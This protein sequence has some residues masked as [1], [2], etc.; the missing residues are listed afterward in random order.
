MCL[1]NFWKRHLLLFFACL[2]S[3]VLL[4]QSPQKDSVINNLDSVYVVAFRSKINSQNIPV[5]V[6]HLS[7]KVLTQEINATL[8]PAIN[9]IAGVKMEQRSPGSY[10]LAIRGS[11]LRSPFGIRNV[12]VYWN[13]ITFTDP[14]GNTYLN[15]LPTSL[16]NTIDIIK[17]P[18]GASYGLGTGGAVL[19]QSNFV[20]DSTTASS[21]LANIRGGSFGLFGQ[22][23]RLT[24][25]Y[26]KT[27]QTF[28]VSNESSNGW[29][30][31]SATDKKNITWFTST[32]SNRQ[33]LHTTLLYTDLMYQTPGGLTLGQMQ[34]NPKW[35][36]QATS[37][38]PGA[39]AQ[40]TAVFNKTLLGSVRHQYQFSKK[41]SWENFILAAQ[42]NFKNPFIT[43]YETRNE[44]NV[45]MGSH[46]TYDAHPA[47]GNVKI[48]MGG[49]WQLQHA[50]IHNY[51]NK[52][53]IID[54]LQF[55]D[56]IRTKQGFLFINTTLHLQKKWFIELGISSAFNRYNYLRTSTTILPRA[57]KVNAGLLAP[58]LGVSYALTPHANLYVQISKGFSPP[59]LAEI[60]PS[61]GL[62]YNA[63]A[64]EFGWNLEGGI[65][66]VAL[67]GK[68]SYELSWYHF[69]VQDA[70]VRQNTN[71]GIE[72]FV[73]AGS[74]KQGGAEMQMMYKLIINKLHQLN[75][76]IGY[77]YQPYRFIHYVQAGNSY[78]G[79]EVTGNAKYQSVVSIDYNYN[80][81]LTAFAT[82]QTLS[83]V[84]LTDANDVYAPA[85]S[86]V[87]LGVSYNHKAIRYFMGIDNVFNTSYSLGND[88][89][90]AGKRY[91]NP[92]APKSLLVGITA[93]LIK[94]SR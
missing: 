43:N 12:K 20:L 61:D 89:N 5:S 91:Y 79:K 30:E 76:K 35:A 84:P 46:I 27:Q 88:I 16:I 51:G 94:R 3:Y 90:A 87:Q 8:L 1:N 24:F 26:K 9:S 18:V 60:R 63:L 44:K 28:F 72:Y 62:F 50:L 6:A 81:K 33:S 93:Q 77:A 69:D 92:A 66:G 19:L 4:A 58:Q 55:A 38:L 31:Q 48:V 39:V 21:T 59:T 78:D 40:Q 80:K 70:I 47:F 86:L 10:R 37:A 13:Q 52:K 75:C 23:V 49:E 73:N 42:T 15:I 85:Y 32:T 14:T 41:L 71:S 11:S 34:Q 7:S 17:G 56:D 67:H 25:K 68:L 82:L 22:D 29:R 2:I 83:A 54:T 74:V 45:S 64:P 57:S 65:K 36:R 53:G